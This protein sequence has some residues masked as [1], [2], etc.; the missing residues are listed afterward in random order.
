M[1]QLDNLSV[2]HVTGTKG[3]GSTCAFTEAILRQH[4]L[5]TGFFSSPHLV[6]VRE[7]IRINNEPISHSHFSRVFWKIY[8]RLEEKREHPYDMPMYFMFLTIMMF[9]VFLEANVDVAIIEVG[10]GGELDCTNIIRNPV[11][12]GITSLGLEHT[13]LLGNS[14]EEIA[15]QKSGIF[16]SNA[17][18]FTMSQPDSVMSILQRRAA[19]RKCRSLQVVPI[20]Q[21][22]QWNSIPSLRNIKFSNI[23]RQN[24]SLSIRLACEWM[25]SCHNKWPSSIVDNCNNVFHYKTQDDNLFE[26]TN[27]VTMALANCRW[28]GRTQI[29]KTSIADFFLDGAHTVES[30]I[31]CISWFKKVCKK[32]SKKFLIFNT[33][34]DRNSCE[35]LN[36]LRSLHFDRV[37]FVPNHA[38]VA[39][40][41]SLTNYMTDE[42]M[43]E[44][45]K[46]K[47]IKHCELWGKNSVFK[48]NVNEILLDIK[49]D[50]SSQ[51]IDDDKVE[52]LVTGSLHLIGALLTILDPDLRMTSNF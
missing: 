20:I 26:Q 12:V 21:D 34:G 51:M 4:G 39:A 24:A 19:E 9:N 48:N 17:T 13:S 36:P 40:I 28:P 42:T 23:Q 46:K 5:N 49:K 45:Q 22:R 3:K 52:I 14:L 29:L 10:I 7:R 44:K 18:A 50:V 16:K 33:S 41:E 25:K 35:L 8:K 6:S 47:C 15:Y 11:C 37:Y 1:E 31:H 2:I 43:I 32:T 30:I 27:E 38:G